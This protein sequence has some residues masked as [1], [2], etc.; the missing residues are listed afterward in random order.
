MIVPMQRVTLLCLASD[1]EATLDALRELG[2]MHLEPVRPPEGK[3]LDA[4]RARLAHIRSA[5]E[6]LPPAAKDQAPTGEPADAVIEQIRSL[7]DEQRVRNEELEA[8]RQERARIAP[9]GDFDPQALAELAVKGVYIQ[10]YQVDAGRKIEAPDD[11]AIHILQKTKAG[12]YFAAVSRAPIAL[13]AQELRMPE[14]PLSEVERRIGDLEG[15][16]AEVQQALQRYAGDLAALQ[17]AANEAE[18]EVRFFEA[19]D[20]MGAESAIAY[21]RGFCPTDAVESLRRAAAEQGWGLQIGEPSDEDAVPTL[22]RYPAWVKPIKAVFDFIGVLP[23]YKEIE[24]SAVFLLFLGIFFGMIVG[25]AG[26]GLIFIALTFW[27]RRKMPNAPAYPFQLMYVMSVCTVVWGTITGTWLGASRLPPLLEGFTIEWLKDTNNVMLL[28]FLIGSI[29]LTIAHLWNAVRSLPSLGALAQLGWIGTTWTMFFMARMM[30]IGQTF[31][32][33]ML[34]IFWVSV[35][36]IVLFM[37]PVK[38]IKHEWFNYVM[39]PLNLVSNFVDVVSY[40]RLYAVGVAGFAVAN[41]FNEMVLAGGWRGIGYSL[42]AALI[43][44][45]GHALNIL[46]CAMGVLV[47]GVRLNT[48]EFAAHLGT[49]W[50]GVAYRPFARLN[51]GNVDQ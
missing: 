27:A 47:H 12:T 51:S 28:C 23:G 34:N 6:A 35:A 31:P 43:L 46:L 30:V 24:S 8:L 36:L 4:A 41:A 45:A 17:R 16:A 29:Q 25:D 11:V 2:V 20:G 13:D 1:R 40:V 32:M 21:L 5:L 14:L 9:Y 7:L 10:L 19:R 22:I 42:L 3:D 37:M 26:Y 18:E 44:F 33:A 49:Q 38:Q 39:L 15:R 50:S 48:L